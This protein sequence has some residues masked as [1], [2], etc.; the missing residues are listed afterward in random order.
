[1]DRIMDITTDRIS[2]DEGRGEESQS[3]LKCSYCVMIDAA[4][5][6]ELGAMDGA[7]TGCSSIID[8]KVII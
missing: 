8:Y 4:T 3:F 2:V 1:M 6:V 7:R 5:A